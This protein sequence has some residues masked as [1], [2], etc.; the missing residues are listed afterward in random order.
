[1]SEQLTTG[2]DR[3]SLVDEAVVVSAKPEASQGSTLASG[4]GKAPLPARRRW[5]SYGMLVFLAFSLGCSEFIVIGIEPELAEN[6]HR[7]LADVGNLISL[8]A[9]SYAIATPTLAILTGRVRRFVL[10]SV[11]LTVFVVANF[12]IMI[13]ANFSTLLLVRVLMGAV[14]GPILAV[15]TTYVSDLLGYKRSSVGIAVIYAAFSIA[16][17][18][19]TSLCRVIVENFS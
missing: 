6:F 10:M 13:A 3:G 12:V 8:F 2:N 5:L 19:S 14:A 7:S 11:Y 9:L 1:M 17:V 4:D 15:A 16:L 18:L